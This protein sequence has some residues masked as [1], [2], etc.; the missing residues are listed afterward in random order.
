MS[1][2]SILT[3]S[4]VTQD[5]GGRRGITGRSPSIRA[6]EGVSMTVKQGDILGIVG[7]SGSGKT[8]LAKIMLGLLKPTQGEIL[9]DGKAIDG[10]SRAKIAERVQFIFQDP[11][12]SLNPRQTVGQIVSYPLYLRGQGAK[13][14]RERK[15]REMLDIVGLSSRFFESYP[16][17]MSGGQRQRVAIARALVTRPDLLIC[18]E[19]TS[20]LDVSVQAQVL[21]LLLDL[22]EEFGLTYVMVSHNM[23]VIQHMTTRVAVMYLGRIVEMDESEKVFESPQHPYTQLLLNSTLTVAQGTGVP[24]LNVDAYARRVMREHRSY[25]GQ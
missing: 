13:I 1:T 2:P 4:D 14:E 6:V 19:P 5:F 21:N 24:Q 17:Q 7:E 15:A 22:R 25:I 11:Y 10:M 23:A 16:S 18:D 8:T 20:A 9:L 12:S 3:L